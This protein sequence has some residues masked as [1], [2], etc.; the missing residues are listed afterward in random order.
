[1]LPQAIG[2][3]EAFHELLPPSDAQATADA[4]LPLDSN[5]RLPGAGRATGHCARASHLLACRDRGSDHPENIHNSK[6]VLCAVD[7]KQAEVQAFCRNLRL[8]ARNRHAGHAKSLLRRQSGC[9]NPRSS[10][11]PHLALLRVNATTSRTL[12][13]APSY[14]V[15]KVYNDKAATSGKSRQERLG[16]GNVACIETLRSRR[17]THKSLECIGTT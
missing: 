17:T 10:H 16:G 6:L 15:Y 11:R 4:V 12:P 14:K 3:R 1:M 5:T 2:F 9:K 13:Q 8:P 7:K